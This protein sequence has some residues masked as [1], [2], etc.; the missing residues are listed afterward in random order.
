MD[1]WSGWLGA[2]V[3]AAVGGLIAFLVA[4][5]VLRKTISEQHAAAARQSKEQ[6]DAQRRSMLFD[7]LGKFV[8]G[9]FGM[10]DAIE[11]GPLA[12]RAAHSRALGGILL[13]EVALGEDEDEIGK[14]LR[15][16]DDVM[17]QF[18]VMAASPADAKAVRPVAVRRDKL[19][20]AFGAIIATVQEWVAHPAKRA[21]MVALLQKSAES[22]EATRGPQ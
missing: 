21:D 1:P 17:W 7:S 13:F 10:N 2:L 15:R 16:I 6:L 22:L 20:D 8:D 14:L 3:G 18:S 12:V 11:H 5:F 19:T 9:T 4:Y